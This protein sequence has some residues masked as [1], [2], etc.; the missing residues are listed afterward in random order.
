MGHGNRLW[1]SPGRLER[2]GCSQYHGKWQK[3]AFRVYVL[4][5]PGFRL[6]RKTSDY[7][8]CFFFF[9][10]GIM[11]VLYFLPHSFQF[12]QKFPSRHKFA[13]IRN[14]YVCMYLEIRKKVDLRINSNVFCFFSHYL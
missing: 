7:S 6:K 12:N 10:D 8:Q 14:M 5:G 4:F 2:E 9:S 1:A 13:L 3:A 11:S